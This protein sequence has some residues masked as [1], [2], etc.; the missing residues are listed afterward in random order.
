MLKKTLQHGTDLGTSSCVVLLT[1]TRHG[2]LTRKASVTHT[3][4]GLGL[5]LQYLRIAWLA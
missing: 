5:Y 4:Q 2:T 3:K 1:E